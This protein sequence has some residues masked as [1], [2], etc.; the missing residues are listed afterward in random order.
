MK[1][2]SLFVICLFPLFILFVGFHQSCAQ[3]IKGTEMQM[4]NWFKHNGFTCK[5]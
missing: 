1:L 4:N 5:T 3:N 2:V